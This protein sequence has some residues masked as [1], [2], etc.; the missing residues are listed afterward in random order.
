MS[1][2]DAQQQCLITTARTAIEHGLDT[3]TVL[4]VPL[5]AYEPALCVH[6]ATFVTL[7]RHHTL[8]GCIGTLTPY[9]PLIV[10]VAAHAYAAAFQDPRFAPLQRHEWAAVKV[11]ISILSAAEAMC[12]SSEEDL[13]CQLQPGIDG[14]ILSQGQQRGT[15]L[16]SVWESLPTPRDFVR[17]LKVKAGF[18]SD[19]WSSQLHIS[20][21]HVE[22]IK[23]K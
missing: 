9:Q 6:A 18:S 22:S 20:R 3:G 8:R 2:T 14:L 15:F 4:S 1:F 11:H 23:E 17:H 19:Y 21:Y 10:D 12:F 16:P 13:I 5:D 7:H